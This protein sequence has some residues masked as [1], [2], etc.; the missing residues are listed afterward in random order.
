MTETEIQ[1]A[2]GK[3]ARELRDADARR[4]AKSQALRNAVLAA[5]K[6]G[7]SYAQIGD[8]LELHRSRIEQIEKGR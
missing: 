3:A 2:L 5:R 1:K 7:W 4:A 6:A 8:A